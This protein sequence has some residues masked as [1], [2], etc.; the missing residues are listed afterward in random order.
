MQF[1]THDLY[2]IIR[3]PV[4]KSVFIGNSPA[5]VTFEIMFYGSG[6]PDPSKGVR[7]VS[8]KSLLILL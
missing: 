5:P 3:H 6:L 4:Y 7:A 1:T 8:T 2:I